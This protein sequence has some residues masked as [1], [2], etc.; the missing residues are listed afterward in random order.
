LSDRPAHL[1]V[2]ID[3]LVLEGIGLPPHSGELVGSA[4]GAALH[5]LLAND[6]IGGWPSAGAVLPVLDAP[7]IGVRKTND[8]FEVGHGIARAVYEGIRDHLTDRGG[9]PGAKGDPLADQARGGVQ[10]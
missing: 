7:A 2:R 1:A 8:P 9:A 4:A 3:R 10:Q 5:R 6:P